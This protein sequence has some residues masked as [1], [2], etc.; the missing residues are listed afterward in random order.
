MDTAVDAGCGP[1]RH[2]LTLCKTARR[3]VAV[4]ISVNMLQS[5]RRQLPTGDDRKVHFIQADIRHLPLKSYSADL[6]VNL[7]VLEHLPGLESD[8]KSALQE[9]VRVL[10]PF[11]LLITEAPLRRHSWWR[12]L[13]QKEAS[14]KETT[15]SQKEK[16]YVRAPLLVDHAFREQTIDE[17]LTHSGFLREKK[18]FIRFFPS[19]LVERHPWLGVFDALLEKLPLLRHLCREA[20]WCVRAP[21][22]RLEGEA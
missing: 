7:E 16:Y 22:A 1:G 20:I 15:E 21:R 4:D 14:F 17:A 13:Y 6:V 10:R 12:H 5:A 18:R 2:T 11:G 8:M 9:F 19:G 3:V